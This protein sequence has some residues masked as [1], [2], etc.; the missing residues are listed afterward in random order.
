VCA[1]IVIAQE[2]GGLV[3]GSHEYFAKTKDTNL[4]QVDEE[5]LTGRK[6]LV[7]R[8]IGGPNVSIVSNIYLIS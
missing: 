7:V 2:A 4:G 3:S 6:Y 5:L 1:G 8:G